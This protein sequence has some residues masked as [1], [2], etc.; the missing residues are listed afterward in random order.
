MRRASHG[1]PNERIGR[2]LGLAI[3]YRG[4]QGRQSF[5]LNFLTDRGPD[6]RRYGCL[7]AF[8]KPNAD[9]HSLYGQPP[10]P[11]WGDV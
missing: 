9:H 7:G 1:N 3:I 8:P 2:D 4:D 10:A 6:S 11:L 5:N